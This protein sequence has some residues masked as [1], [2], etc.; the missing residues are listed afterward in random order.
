MP[1]R[2]W[3]YLTKIGAFIIFATILALFFAPANSTL[4]LTRTI[5]QCALVLLGII[6]ATFGILMIVGKLRMLCPF[7]KKSGQVGGD[8]QRGMWM[9]CE[10]CG[11]VHGSGP[12]R[13]KIVSEKISEDS[14]EFDDEV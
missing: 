3:F 6:G 12:L 7:C 9:I 4:G 5:A 1:F 13:L 8:K 11:F 14:D 2:L 10:S